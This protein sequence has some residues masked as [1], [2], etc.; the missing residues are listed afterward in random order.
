ML[1][2][3]DVSLYGTIGLTRSSSARGSKIAEFLEN[4]AIFANSTEFSRVH[5]AFWAKRTPD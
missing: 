3:V 4:C 2:V 1:G 5:I